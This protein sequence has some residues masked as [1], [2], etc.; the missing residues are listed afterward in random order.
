ME[1]Q[2][3]QQTYLNHLVGAGVRQEHAQQLLQGLTREQLQG[4]CQVLPSRQPEK[5][6]NFS[7]PSR[8]SSS[9][10]LL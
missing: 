2:Q 5:K 3:L 1:L 7:S 4:L 6:T 10:Y 8:I 9:Q